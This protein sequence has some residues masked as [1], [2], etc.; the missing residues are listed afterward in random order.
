MSTLSDAEVFVRFI[1]KC[2]VDLVNCGSEKKESGIALRGEGED[3]GGGG[4][5]GRGAGGGGEGGGDTSL[6]SVCDVNGEAE[7]NRNMQTCH[8]H[9]QSDGLG[10]SPFSGHVTSIEGACS[11][12]RQ[13]DTVAALTSSGDH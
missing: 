12:V 1:E 4:G 10:I 6:Q 7:F 2:F 13:G 5:G 3:K 9:T 11:H 8:P